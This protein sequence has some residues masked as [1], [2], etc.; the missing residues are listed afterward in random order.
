MT[1]VPVV[2][3]RSPSSLSMMTTTTHHRQGLAYAAAGRRVCGDCLATQ[4]TERQIRIVGFDYVRR[5]GAAAAGRWWAGGAGAWRQADE[6]PTSSAVVGG[7][8]L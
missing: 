1:G 5:C 2:V 8:L 6:R 4:K 7:R 3:G